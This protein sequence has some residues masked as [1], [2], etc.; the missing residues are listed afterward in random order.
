LHLQYKQLR[1]LKTA[2]LASLT[3]LPMG[4]KCSANS[5]EPGWNC[6]VLTLSLQQQIDTK[7]ISKEIIFSRLQPQQRPAGS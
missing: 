2:S 6:L 1:Y 5:E 4:K 3:N 7:I